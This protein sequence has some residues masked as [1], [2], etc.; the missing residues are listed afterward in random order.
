MLSLNFFNE[1]HEIPRMQT[2]MKPQ[3]ASATAYAEEN[4]FQI[5]VLAGKCDFGKVASKPP[6]KIPPPVVATW[7]HCEVEKL[8]Y[9]DIDNDQK[10]AINQ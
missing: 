8:Q 3:P 5:Q 10:T 1:I 9:G 4:G 7:S 6:T 2:K